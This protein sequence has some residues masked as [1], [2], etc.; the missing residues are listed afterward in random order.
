MRGADAP[1]EV[2]QNVHVENGQH[3][4]NESEPDSPVKRGRKRRRD[5]QNWKQNI[6]KRLR[7]RGEEYVSQKG[8]TVRRKCVQVCT[9]KCK[10]K[11]HDV[12]DQ[13]RTNFH[14]TFWNLGSNGYTAQRQF[15]I[16]YCRV[17][18]VKRRTSCTEEVDI[19]RRHNTYQYFMSTK[20]GKLQVCKSFFLKTLDIDQSWVYTTM[21]KRFHGVAMEDQRGK[22][23]THTL[24]PDEEKAIREHIKKFPTM[25]AHYVRSGAKRYLDASLSIS[26][27]YSLYQDECREK[28]TKAC[29]KTKYSSVFNHDFNL[30]FHRPKKDMCCKCNQYYGASEEE[31]KKMQTEFDAHINRKNSIRAE[32]NNDKEKAQESDTFVSFNF[33][34]QA[35][36]TTPKVFDKP[37]FYKRK[38]NVYNETTYDVKTKEGVCRVWPESEGKRGANEVATCIHNNIKSYPNAE[39]VSMYSDSCGGENRNS[40]FSIMC[41]HT[42]QESDHLQAI[43]H[44][45]FEPGHSE[46]EADSMHS[47]IHRASK[48]AEIQVPQDWGN[49]M[50]LAR[51]SNPYKIIQ[52]SYDQFKDWKAYGKMQGWNNFKTNTAGEK[53]K[54]LQIR[55]MRYEKKSIGIIKYKYTLN[56]EYKEIAICGTRKS[57]RKTSLEVDHDVPCCYMEP[58]RISKAKKDDLLSLCKSNIIRREF[59]SFY[60]D[61]L[62][63]NDIKGE[64][65]DC[66]DASE[67]SES[68]EE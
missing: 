42:V 43:E 11:C 13:D 58:L 39:T 14:Q 8:K 40:I 32:K 5:S 41:L 9:C 56:E 47:T 38:L 24:E 64:R 31:K 21:S 48:H 63:D 16:E 34:K 54:W 46:M 44:T 51:R 15:L 59:H 6:R 10:F 22:K 17:I 23:P 4:C 26:K 2:N 66:P 55:K 29:S 53:V 49:V 62:T 35:I 19:S 33:D 28:G 50:R 37:V 18:S 60:E 30:G 65:L 3:S 67:E 27:M 52:M 36:L 20:K 68:E 61:L 25:G 7:D 57:K 45:Y 1:A 12:D